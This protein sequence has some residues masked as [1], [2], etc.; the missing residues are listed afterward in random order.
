M[1]RIKIDQSFI[2]KIDRRSGDRAIVQAVIDLGHKLDCEIVAEGVE[3]E[4]QAALLR[5]MG[6]DTAQGYLFG[7][8]FNAEQSGL[9]LKAQA[10]KQM[11]LLRAVA[12][13]QAEKPPM[14]NVA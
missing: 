3:T 14:S 11:R 8:P 7:R 2:K 12:D 1:H 6:C 10:V 9:F 13:Q 5:D 4:A